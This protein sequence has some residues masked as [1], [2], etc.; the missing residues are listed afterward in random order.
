VTL[1]INQGQTIDSVPRPAQTS[2]AAPASFQHELTSASTA[3]TNEINVLVDK[4][5]EAGD[6]LAQNM[7]LDNLDKYKQALKKL[8]NQVS[9]NYGLT[10]EFLFNHHGHRRILTAIHQIKQHAEEL[11]QEITSQNPNNLK[12]LTKIDSIKGLVVDLLT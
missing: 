1:R 8:L 5:K 9:R 6:R 2:K 10:S 12:I 11:T 3:T 4:L 7:T